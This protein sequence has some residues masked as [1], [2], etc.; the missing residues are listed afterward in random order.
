MIYFKFCFIYFV[1]IAGFQWDDALTARLTCYHGRACTRCCMC[2]HH[3]HT[4][5]RIPESIH[6]LGIWHSPP[7]EHKHVFYK[8]SMVIVR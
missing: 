1:T 8:D 5:G 7:A 4:L 3:L 6:R 2:D